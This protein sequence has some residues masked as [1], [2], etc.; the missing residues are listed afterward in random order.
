MNCHFV[1]DE[2]VL[3]IIMVLATNGIYI[4]IQLHIHRFYE[5]D[6]QC[7]A[8][9]NKCFV[10]YLVVCL[11]HENCL[12]ASVH[13]YEHANAGKKESILIRFGKMVSL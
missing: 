4:N 1:F 8:N 7:M 12:C 11:T 2:Y 9:F 6:S 5:F 13:G 10:T 3:I